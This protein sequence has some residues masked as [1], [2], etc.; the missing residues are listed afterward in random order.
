M[1][2]DQT[3]SVPTTRTSDLDKAASL[4][5]G[6]RD[7]AKAQNRAQGAATEPTEGVGE[8]HVTLSSLASTI[9][10]EPATAGKTSAKSLD[11]ARAQ[12]VQA[13]LKN[14]KPVPF[15][16]EKGGKHTIEVDALPNQGDKKVYE[17]TLDGGASFQVR[18]P[19]KM[20]A[21]SNTIGEIADYV[22]QTPKG[23]RPAVDTVTVQEGANPQDA[24]WAKQYNMPGFTSAATGGGGNVTFWH[25]TK[26]L[27]RDT[28]NHEMGHNI[29]Q[30]TNINKGVR[31]ADLNI[32]PGWAKAA[33]E[34]KKRVSKYASA[35]I[36]E[37]FAETWRA[38]QAARSGGS[39][40]L[41][42]FNRTYPHRAAILKELYKEQLPA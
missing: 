4:H 30:A 14:H 1:Y 6:F 36:D 38:Y 42:T 9:L 19:E 34:D 33:S 21:K 12:A 40:A 3:S 39:K 29:A 17:V 11:E 18:L 28:M 32:P 15:R 37:D 25:G 35:H 31:T 5:R 23:L 24:Y 20:G 8:D 7:L 26:Y 27:N 41:N 16:T 22:S 13:S 10:E 2:I